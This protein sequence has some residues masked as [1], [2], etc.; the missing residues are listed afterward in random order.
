MRAAMNV[1]PRADLV[2]L[3]TRRPIDHGLPPRIV[4]GLMF[5]GFCGGGIL[6]SGVL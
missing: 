1:R 6:E 3:L 4:E 2:L 5:P